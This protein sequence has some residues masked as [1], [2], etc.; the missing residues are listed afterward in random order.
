MSTTIPIALFRLG[1]IVT[2]QR[3]LARLSQSDILNGIRRH[4]AG[5]WGEVDECDR[6]FNYRALA[7]GGRLVSVYYSSQGT[8]FCLITEADRSVTTVLLPD[9]Y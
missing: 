5:D 7:K 8:A 4:L 1:K 6:Q 2:T 3:A 9:E